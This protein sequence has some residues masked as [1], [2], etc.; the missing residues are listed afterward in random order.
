[1]ARTRAQS[2]TLKLKSH[3][4]PATENQDTST[5]RF[6]LE[7]SPRPTKLDQPSKSPVVDGSSGVISCI[8]FWAREGKW[9]KEYFAPSSLDRILARR[10]SL[11]S[12]SRKR[13]AFGSDQ[14]LRGE[15][16]APY[17][18]PRYKILLESRA[19]FMHESDL[20]I[21]KQ[22]EKELSS[23]LAS[24]Q[25]VPNDTPFQDDL[26]KNTCRR[27]EDRNEDRIMRDITPLIVPPADFLSIR[28]AQ[29]LNILIE[30]IN[31][32]WSNSIPL[33]GSQPQPDYSLG[34]RCEAFNDD[35]LA[36]LSPFI[37]DF[38]GGDVSFFMA[39]YLMYF[40]FLTCEVKC[41]TSAL[42]LADCQNV[43]SMTL[44][45]RAV[46]ELFRA[47]KC[48]RDIHRQI[49]GYSIS[50]DHRSVRIY[51]HYPVIDGEDTKYYRHPIRSFDFTALDG[52]ERWTAYRFMKNVYEH[53]VP[54]HFKRI[55]AAIDQLPLDLELTNEAFSS[56]SNRITASS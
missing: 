45:V 11:S 30:S 42:D 32:V 24:Y 28:G 44:A 13:S 5:A 3:S 35:Q 40:S 53:W 27:V 25:T 34:F 7:L 33:T 46:V 29:H 4:S 55:C 39:T 38:L 19:S 15:K 31:E 47:A 50:H 10:R 18:D 52:K 12:L 16:S 14:K 41:G 22:C 36:K 51:G 20:G 2:A 56:A 48:E 21:T 6:D 9:P 43:H 17:G 23:F 26:F 49:L 37:G 8:G 1:M 54:L